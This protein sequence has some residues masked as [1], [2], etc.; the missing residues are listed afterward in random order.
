MDSLWVEEVADELLNN[1][2]YQWTFCRER[3][4]CRVVLEE[5]VR[6]LAEE[7]KENKKEIVKVVLSIYHSLLISFDSFQLQKKILIVLHILNS[8]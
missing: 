8:E 6:I 4:D 2:Q 1:L 7:L 5:V 3:W